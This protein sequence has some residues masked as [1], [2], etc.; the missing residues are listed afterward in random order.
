[1]IKTTKILKIVIFALIAA[2]IGFSVFYFW[3][4]STTPQEE[5]QNT[6]LPEVKTILVGQTNLEGET[7]ETVGIIK[8]AS[9]VEV[10][11]LSP[12]KIKSIYFNVGQYVNENQILAELT[13]RR[14]EESLQTSKISLRASEDNLEN[15]RALHQKQLN[16]AKERAAVRASDYLN[17]IYNTLA[18]VDYI[19]KVDGPEQ[20]PGIAYT[21]GAA[22][23]QGLIDAKNSYLRAKKTYTELKETEIETEN[24][25]EILQKIIRNFQE[26]TEAVNDTIYVLEKTPTSIYFSQ[27]SLVSQKNAFS[28]LKSGVLLAQTN[29]ESEKQSIEIIKLN[30]KREEDS[31]E[32]A[33]QLAKNQLELAQIAYQKLNV[34]SPLTGQITMDY[35]NLGQEIN[36]GQPIAQISQTG[37][38]KIETNLT[39]EDASKIKIWQKALVGQEKTPAVVTSIN[40]TVDP[41]TKKVKVEL[42]FTSFIEKYISGAFVDVFIK[43]NKEQ[44]QETVFIPLSALIVGQNESFVFVIEN[45]NAQKRNVIVGEVEN[46][47]IEI[48]EGLRNGEQLVIEGKEKI[49]DNQEVKVLN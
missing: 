36:P 48:K 44:G 31:L 33:L 47:K 18:Q 19:I 14:T 4:E 34:L 23:A 11:S 12:G 27:S 28:V 13:D 6:T 46:Q 10:V 7:I 49:K 26:V 2:G 17:T 42:A 20:F 5:N 1:M 8:P 9:Q 21:L 22:S 38:V 35:V 16:D 3:P 37:S 32:N 25:E 45:G 30:N 24:I 29:T 40:P 43:T 39:S 41:L 15:T